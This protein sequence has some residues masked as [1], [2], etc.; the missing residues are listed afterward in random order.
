MKTTKE[1]LTERME[2][3]L[4]IYCEAVINGKPCAMLP[5]QD[6]YAISALTLIQ[7]HRLR[8]HL[9]YL[10][11]GWATLWIYEKEYMLEII[12]I[13][14]NEPTT[15]YEHWILGKAFGYSDE[16]IEKFCLKKEFD[17]KRRVRIAKTFVES[18]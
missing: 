10:A 16:A 13:L 5:I 8:G 3:E 15:V 17:F 1:P 4:Q 11:K 18:L 9:E 14:P 12:K 7:N 6:R 2:G